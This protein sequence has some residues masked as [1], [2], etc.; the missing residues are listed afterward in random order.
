MYLTNQQKLIPASMLDVCL[1]VIL[2]CSSFCFELAASIY[3]RSKL[4]F[5]FA[6]HPT[7]FIYFPPRALSLHFL[8]MIHKQQQA[9]LAIS[10]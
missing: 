8:R 9:V 2:C 5:V 10:S 1:E 6:S 4:P 3:I 7:F